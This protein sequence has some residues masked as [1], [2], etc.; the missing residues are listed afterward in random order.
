MKKKK[1]NAF[2]SYKEDLDIIFNSFIS[3]IN[4]ELLSFLSRKNKL[5]NNVELK[6]SHSILFEQ[7]DKF[8]E[9]NLTLNLF[10]VNLIFILE[11]YLQD[12]I[13]EGLTN[14]PIKIDKLVKNYRWDRKLTPEDVISGPQI[15]AQEIIQNTIFHNL[16]RVDKIYKIVFGFSII[17]LMVDDS[18]WSAIEIRHKIVHRGG[19]IGSQRIKVNDDGF[20]KAVN[21]INS[22]IEN[23]EFYF[24]NNRLKK[25][26]PN[27][28]KRYY[29]HYNKLSNEYPEDFSLF[30]ALSIAKSPFFTAKSDAENL[31][32]YIVIK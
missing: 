30:N 19:K 29:E 11:T 32:K 8:E 24:I 10:F 14:D 16:K 13:T 15:L 27:Y 25:A 18:V 9:E 4:Y 7:I 1:S 2:K 26:F 22:W 5:C 20:L 12:R 3:L 17:D 31:N 21:A 23:I 6:K 28:R